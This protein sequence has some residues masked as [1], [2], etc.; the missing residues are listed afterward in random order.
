[1]EEE[2]NNITFN[3]YGGNNQIL[4]NAQEGNQFFIG[5]SAIKLA[6]QDAGQNNNINGEYRFYV[7]HDAVNVP[8]LI[9]KARRYIVLHAAFY[10]KYGFDNQ[11]DDVSKAM[12]KNSNL[13]LTAIFTDVKAPWVDEFAVQSSIDDANHL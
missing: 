3:I 10:P 6:K 9:R 8:E 13:R 7:G 11:G 2:K 12:A 5:D 1:M 4:P